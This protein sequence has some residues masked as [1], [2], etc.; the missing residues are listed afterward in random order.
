ADAGT[1]GTADAGSY[2]AGDDARLNGAAVVAAPVVAA[3]V[4]NGSRDV[5]AASGLVSCCGRARRR[6]GADP[7]APRRAAG[8]PPAPTLSSGVWTAERPV[9]A[10]GLSNGESRRPRAGV[11]EPRIAVAHLRLMRGRDPRHTGESDL[12]WDHALRP[13]SRQPVSPQRTA[14]LELR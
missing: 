10:G 3:S 5:R 12:P 7:P 2:S 4:R 1:H 6:H 14:R 13:E 8:R 11:R 9:G